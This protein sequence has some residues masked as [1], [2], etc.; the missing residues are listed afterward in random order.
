MRRRPGRVNLLSM[1]RTCALIGLF[2]ALSGCGVAGTGAAA[3]AGG[4]SEA[5]QAAQAHA[6]EERV[7]QQL[8]NAAREGA[9][10]RAGAE[11]QAK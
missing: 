5:Q 3:A 8:D 6:T 11:E 1:G 4:A 10:Q 2:L 7:R 9:A